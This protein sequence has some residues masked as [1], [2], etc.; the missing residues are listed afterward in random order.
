MKGNQPSMQLSMERRVGSGAI[1]A[2]AGR[3]LGVLA[4]ALM[5]FLLPRF[6][7]TEQYGAFSLLAPFML[8]ASVVGTLG[9]NDGNVRLLSEALAKSDS[10]RL[11]FVL[12]TSFWLTISI[13]LVVSFAAAIW[14]VSSISKITDHSPAIV[15]GP[16][17]VIGIVLLALHLITAESLRGLH[18]IRIAS[19]LSGGGTGGALVT[20]VFTLIVS[21][22]YA[23]G[24]ISLSSVMIA[25]VV[26][27]A[28]VLPF[29]LASLWRTYGRSMH[30]LGSA[31]PELPAPRLNELL[32]VAIPL[33][34]VHL[35]VFFTMNADVW[36]VGWFFDLNDAGLYAAA[37]RL[38]LMV[39]LPGQVAAQAVMSSIADL[40]ARGRLS[41]LE[42][43]LRR[44]ALFAAAPAAA[45]GALLLIIPGWILSTSCGPDYAAAAPILVVLTVGNL[46]VACCG[47]P[48]HTLIMTGR[49]YYGLVVYAIAAAM[50]AILG[51]WAAHHY[52][53]LG[54]ALTSAFCLAFQSFASWIL[55]RQTVGIWTHPGWIQIP[56]EAISAPHGHPKNSTATTVELPASAS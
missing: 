25:Y 50:L 44:T 8:L 51:P 36:I 53:V 34:F 6:L 42:N 32:A 2:L 38:M 41:E 16:T 7:N 28:V 46:L 47:N 14:L 3:L 12:R 24:L 27:L 22:V 37:R 11:K 45:V 30:E 54:V 33:M 20:L 43:I 40:A 21:L 31:S 13:A 10:Q 15:L 35:L 52:G 9:L 18:E 49:H 26:S 1:W 17:L 55:A 19:L 23:W 4:Q 29:G 48:I 56:R 39:T 5:I